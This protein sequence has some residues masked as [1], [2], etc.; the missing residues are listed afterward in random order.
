MT[1][2]T[3]ETAFAL[4]VALLAAP[5]TAAPAAAD[6]ARGFGAVA[7]GACV[8]LE[9]GETIARIDAGGSRV[10]ACTYSTC[11]TMDVP[12]G[13]VLSKEP[14]PPAAPLSGTS[15]AGV[16]E[17]GLGDEVGVTPAGAY[18]CEGAE[19]CRFFPRARPGWPWGLAARRPQ[20]F[21]SDS[22][23]TV[24]VIEEAEDNAWI[25]VSLFDAASG[26]RANRVSLPVDSADYSVSGA[27]FLGE[28]LLVHAV[29]CCGPGGYTF[30]VG[31]SEGEVVTVELEDRFVYLAHAEDLG[32]GRWLLSGGG[33]RELA[34]FDLSGPSVREE[35]RISLLDTLPRE[36]A[37]LGGEP[38]TPDP[39]SSGWAVAGPDGTA[40]M[41]WGAPLT[42]S[43]TAVDWRTGQILSTWVPRRCEPGDADP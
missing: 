36:P 25:E 31:H 28:T 16:A 38:I 39:G 8:S 33:R 4:F 32:D 37:E 2:C 10:R 34:V 15:E 35:R 23:R 19:P 24:A 3:R 14:Y 13:V 20:A 22:G 6:E 1:H 11:F 12:G 40:H 21:R 7:S 5:F 41:V 17:P 27:Q 29:V 9:E 43:V 18:V 30:L 42:G 26:A